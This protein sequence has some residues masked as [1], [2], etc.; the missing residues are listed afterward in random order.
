MLYKRLEQH[1]LKDY[2]ANPNPETG[3]AAVGKLSEQTTNEEAAASNDYWERSAPA[4]NE[5]KVP[6]SIKLLSPNA[7]D[8]MGA[9]TRVMNR[10]TASTC[11]TSTRRR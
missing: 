11:R 8:S 9:A 5:H 1:Y 2:L 7:P 6:Q 10:R 4:W 3:K